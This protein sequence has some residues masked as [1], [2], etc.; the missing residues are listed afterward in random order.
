[1]PVFW[2]RLRLSGRSVKHPLRRRWLY[3]GFRCLQGMARRLP[4][5]VAQVIGSAIGYTAYAVSRQN[6]QLIWSHLRGAFGSR[7]TDRVRHRIARGVCA[8]LGK[9]VVEWFV[10]DRLSSSAVRQL[11][12]VQG[13]RHMEQALA[14]GRGVIGISAHFGNWE[15]LPMMMGAYGFKGGV[16]ARRLRYPEYESFLVEMRRR[17]GMPT[18]E[19]GSL[20]DVARLL[21]QNQIV[22]MLPDQD[23]VSLEGVFVDFFGRPA[24]TPVGPAALSLMTGAAIVPCF[25]IR[26][27]RRFRLVIEEPIPQVRTGDRAHDILAIT[28][29]WSRVVESYIRCYPE[30]WVWMHRRWKTQPASREGAAGRRHNPVRV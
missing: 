19:R 28:Q 21:H 29:A 6:R 9:T 16:L 30:Q 26:L 12:D 11:V 1:M 20:K 3:V 17:K 10:I 24:Y 8:H 22:G 13:L 4:L 15:L 25:V 2:Q 23:V 7:L 5:P 27:G 18:L 14:R